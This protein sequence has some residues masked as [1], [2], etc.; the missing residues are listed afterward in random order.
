MSTLLTSAERAP[1]DLLV[2]RLLL[3]ELDAALIESLAREE[4]VAVLERADPEARASLSQPWTRAAEEDAREEYARLFLLPNGVP[5]FA[6]A[7]IEGEREQL[8]A[9]LTTFVSRAMTALDRTTTDQQGNL[10]LDHLGLLLELAATA[11]LS[12]REL[13]RDM[14]EHLRKQALGPWVARFGAALRAK[15][16]LPLYRA[17]GTL[18]EQLHS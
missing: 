17:A 7:W 13:D 14:A 12:H 2:S 16:R 5:P 1:I 6:S 8:G 10:P 15:A 11:S 9:Q 4:I 3:S 18:L